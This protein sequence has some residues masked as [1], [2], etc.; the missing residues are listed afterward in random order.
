MNHR[1]R[2]AVVV[3]LQLLL[4]AGMAAGRQ[5]VLATGTV[6]TLETVP[7][8][9]RDLFRG[10]YVTLSYHISAVNPRALGV[11]EELSPGDVIYVGLARRG[12]H[13]V[14]ASASP[15]SKRPA[16]PYLRGRVRWGALDRGDVNV[17]YGIE[18]YFVPEGTGRAIEST[19]ESLVVEVAVGRDGTGVIRRVLLRGRPVP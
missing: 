7:V 15:S 14:A 19:R 6:V 10:D 16:H 4:L 18:T 8:D 2:V 17:E 3:A 9:P 1:R 11:T 12:D 5:W 13:W